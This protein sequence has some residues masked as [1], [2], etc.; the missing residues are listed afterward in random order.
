MHPILSSLIFVAFLTAVTSQCTGN[1]APSCANWVKNGYCSNSAS[2]MET[3]KLYCGVAC[4]FCNRDGTQTEAGGGSTVTCSDNNANCEKWAA[5]KD[6]AFCASSKYSVEMKT[7]YCAKTCAFE[8]KPDA[9]C[10]L[11]T[12]TDDKLTRGTPSNSTGPAPGEA[13]ASGA[14]APTT[15][16]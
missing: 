2:P 14:A 12:L 16:S 13:V 10:V 6:N 3:R 4:G 5:N 15:V 11:Y 1:D 7:T 9:D 8:I